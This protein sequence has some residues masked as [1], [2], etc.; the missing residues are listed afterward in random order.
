MK[1]KVITINKILIIATGPLKILIYIL[2]LINT[3]KKYFKDVSIHVL[4]SPDNKEF[5]DGYE[6][7][8]EILLDKRN[9]KALKGIK[10][11][12]NYVGFIKAYDF[13][14]IIHPNLQWYYI[15]VGFFSNIPL[16]IGHDYKKLL[17]NFLTHKV[18]LNMF[19]YSKHQA[20]ENL[21]LLSPLLNFWDSNTEFNFLINKETSKMIKQKINFDEDLNYILIHVKENFFSG[22]W[23]SDMFNS[24]IHKLKSIK[25]YKVLVIGKQKDVQLIHHILEQFK[26]SIINLTGDLS[27]TELKS[28]IQLSSI[29]IGD[30]SE[31]V[32]IGAAL[33][34]HIV[35]I[36]TNSN[37]IENKFDPWKTNHVIIGD[38][39]N[40]FNINTNKSKQINHILSA[41]D[42]LIKK[43]VIFPRKQELYWFKIKS[44]VLVHIFNK[45]QEEIKYLIK[46]VEILNEH[47]ISCF[48][49]T[50]DKKCMSLFDN[51]QDIF[52]AHKYNL[53]AWVRFLT[54]NKITIWHSIN[55]KHIKLWP[56]IIQYLINKFHKYKPTFISE[57]FKTESVSELLNF[58]LKYTSK[59]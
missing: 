16:R 29:I 12:F 13:D 21:N 22:D 52:Y 23:T 20:D 10:D 25:E 45:N 9:N 42:F 31:V 47:D 14:V 17:N 37:L 54:K 36:N 30:N 55:N 15:L 58:Y 34:K 19:N 39:N 28:V 32:H 11:F 27:I 49:S 43:D 35:S 3:L 46:I 5:I 4:I 26:E 1:S 57:E 2:P 59:V 33:K 44:N 18:H 50:T 24:L 8:T 38:Y 48:I 41:I 7:I 51:V 6:S 56:K 53:L 40:K